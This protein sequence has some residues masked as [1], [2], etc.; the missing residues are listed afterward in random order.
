MGQTAV[1][2]LGNELVKKGFPIEKYGM[3]LFEQAKE[4]EGQQKGYSEQDMIEAS[5]YGYNF[6]KTTQFPQQ[7]FEDSCIRN[8]QQWLTKFKKL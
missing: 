1:E 5:K 7:E 3:D 8:T 2:W 4:M 6:H